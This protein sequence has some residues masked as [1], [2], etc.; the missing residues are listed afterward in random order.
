MTQQSYDVVGTVEEKTFVEPMSYTVT[1]SSQAKTIVEPSNEY[2]R[3]QIDT[4]INSIKAKYDKETIG[5]MT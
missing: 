3:I 1:S 4:I 2:E 5:A